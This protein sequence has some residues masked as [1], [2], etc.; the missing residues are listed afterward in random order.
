MANEGEGAA[1]EAAVV[2]NP[3]DRAVHAALADFHLERGDP[4]GEF[5]RVQLALEELAPSDPMASGLREQEKCLRERTPATGFGPA[6]APHLPTTRGLPSR[7]PAAGLTRRAPTTR[8]LSRALAKSPSA[9]C[10]ENGVIADTAGQMPFDR[11]EAF[12]TEVLAGS[13]VYYPDEAIALDPLA[14]SDNLR[15][16]RV[17]QLGD[18]DGALTDVGDRALYDFLTHLPRLEELTLAYYQLE[19]RRLFALDLPNLRRLHVSGVFSYFLEILG[20]NASLGQLT[21]LLL[22]PAAQGVHQKLMTA[23]ILRLVRSPHLKSL[24]HLQLRFCALGDVVCED[25]VAS[26]ILARLEVLDLQYSDITDDGAAR[27]AAS[28]ALNTLRCLDISHNRLSERGVAHLRRTGI[29]VLD[30]G[31]YVAGEL[32]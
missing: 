2:A 16:L 28:P 27:L 14:H 9:A 4:R 29:E 12:G 24:A 26:G 23:D 15:N 3:D 11:N 22:E 18:P 31:Q 17:L 6:L 10:C 7:S 13:A 20:L 32:D 25:I 19:T 30:A 5:I 21:H 1:L 8:R